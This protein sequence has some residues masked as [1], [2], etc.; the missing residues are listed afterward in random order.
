MTW[1]EIES[2]AKEGSVTFSV[3]YLQPGWRKFVVLKK[4]TA[5]KFVS[6]RT[7]MVIVTS[8]S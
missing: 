7:T 1:D 5:L 3:W 6:C 8:L 4:K 2:K